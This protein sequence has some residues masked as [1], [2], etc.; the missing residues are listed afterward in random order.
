MS[1]KSG[2]TKLKVIKSA[3][4]CLA[5]LGIEATTFQAIADQAKLSQPL[6]VYH[7]KTRSNIFASVIGHIM[8]EALISTEEALKKYPS[9]E[10]QLK[11]YIRISLKIFR[12]DIYTARIYM[13]FYYLSS[14]DPF[15][16]AMNEQIKSEATQR[17]LNILA[18]GIGQGEF[19]MEDPLLTA[20]LIHTY[21]VGLLLNL[22]TENAKFTDETFLEAVQ[23]DCLKM[24]GLTQ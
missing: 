8:D 10:I 18:V 11:E 5:E 12:Q 14:F 21:L 1:E 13:A 4:K 9:A 6:V 15:Y 16:R 22:A 17:V 7:L 24:A 20:K 3:T 2:K 19:K 23:K